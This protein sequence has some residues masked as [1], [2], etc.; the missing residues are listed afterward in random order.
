M[1]V[2]EVLDQV[3][4]EMGTT[5]VVITHNAMIRKMAHR[6]VNFADGKLQSEAVNDSRLAPHEIDW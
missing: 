5:T 4:R 3:N 1:R 6:V 2:L